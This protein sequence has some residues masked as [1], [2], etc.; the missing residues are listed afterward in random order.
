MSKPYLTTR[1]LSERFAVTPR[2][3]RTLAKNGQLPKPL[4][5]GGSVRW[6]F[7]DIAE[8]EKMPVNKQARN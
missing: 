5:I 1:D 7:S 6:S 2:T 3:I 4:K 8:F